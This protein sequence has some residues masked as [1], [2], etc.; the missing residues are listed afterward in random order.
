MTELHMISNKHS[1]KTY[2]PRET[3]IVRARVSARDFKV[4][5]KM[6]GKIVALNS[7][8]EKVWRSYKAG[9]IRRCWNGLVNARKL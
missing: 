9:P 7:K 2:K 3:M 6:C 5:Y 1:K 4:G 8:G